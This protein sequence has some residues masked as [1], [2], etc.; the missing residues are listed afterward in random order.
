M[1]MIGQAQVEGKPLRFA[2]RDRVAPGPE[3][4]KATRVSAPITEASGE[5]PA[6]AR[7]DFKRLARFISAHFGLSAAGYYY[8]YS[9]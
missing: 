7:P 5:P 4:F 2:H 8:C 6:K 1:G 3:I 9:F